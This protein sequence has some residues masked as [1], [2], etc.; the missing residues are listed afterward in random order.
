ME[1][2]SAFLFISDFKRRQSSRFRRG[3]RGNRRGAGNQKRRGEKEEE[4]EELGT[5]AEK[6]GGWGESQRHAGKE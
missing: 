5:K 6:G 2:L 4:R 1:P 3:R